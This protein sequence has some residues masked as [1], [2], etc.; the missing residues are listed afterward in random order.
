M[1]KEDLVKELR[2]LND[3]EVVEVFYE[4]FSN[5]KKVIDEDIDEAIVIGEASYSPQ[6]KEHYTEFW[7]LPMPG[8]PQLES[9][10]QSGKCEKCKALI[11]SVSKEAQCPICGTLVE[12]T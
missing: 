10:L 5:R 6:D 3:K 2:K 12:C 8:L 7:A 9:P 4:A 11:A 1:K